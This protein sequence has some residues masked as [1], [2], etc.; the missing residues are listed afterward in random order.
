LWG[1]Q[2][3]SSLQVCKMVITVESTFQSG[4]LFFS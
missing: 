3:H 4:N 1:D 2:S